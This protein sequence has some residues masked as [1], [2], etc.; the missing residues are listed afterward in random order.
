MRKINRLMAVT[1]FRFECIA[2]DKAKAN[3]P[4]IANGERVVIPR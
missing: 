2:C 3:P 4:L 1:D